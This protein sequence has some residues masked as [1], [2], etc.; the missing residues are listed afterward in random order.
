MKNEY[1]VKDLRSFIAR[2]DEVGQLR[3]I[4]GADWN[5]E[6]GAITE[7]VSDKA[8]P[9]LMFDNIAGYP[10]GF[11][12]LSN[13]F[14][15]H[16]RFG[17]AL[18]FEP[19]AHGIELLK[20]WRKKSK[21]MK[22][23]P[24]VEVPNAPVL[25]NRMEGKDVDVLAFPAPKWHE[26]DGG[27]YLGTGCCVITVDP[28][29]GHTNLGTYRCMVQNKT[30]VSIKANKGKHGRIAMEKYHAKGKPAPVAI[31]LGP[32]P[33]SF[34]SA[35]MSASPS[36]E[37]YELA[38]AIRDAPVEIVR[39]P[40]HGLPIPAYSEIVLEGEVP[41]LDEMELPQ[42]G[43]F[44][45]WAGYY[46]DT[47]TGEVPVMNVKAIY[48]RNNPII[49]GM[50]PMKPPNHYMSLPL[51]AAAL[52]DQLEAA[53]IPGITG[54][55]SFVYGGVIGPF[56]AI[57]IKQSYM[58]HS[59]QTL[60]CATGTRAGA[61]GGKFVV[62]VDDD[63]DVTD[64]QDVIWAMGTRCDPAESIDFLR[65]IWTSPADPAIS[66]MARQKRPGQSSSHHGYTM[67]RVLIDACRP[68]SW[69]DEFPEV[70]AF[71]REVKEQV[72]KKWNL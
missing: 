69:M 62:V 9:A 42:E 27:R 8:G 54:V 23:V 24:P 51:G 35:V 25:E 46:A 20:Q 61:Y 39:S 44:G 58:G 1:D 12:V 37:E 63:V 36:T 66:P 40:I 18:G 68:Y 43:P 14:R 56:V 13:A 7:A 67:T 65:G 28:E 26:Q 22:P 2:I 53:G 16:D 34:L 50:P 60:A 17:V 30:Q 38:G 49:L 5:V 64:L 19:G 29:N 71:P 55:W 31:S 32:D 59:K 47:T 70:N 10:K 72:A 3:R 41:P 4:D 11:R 6:I 15:T 52:W 21:T 57:S 45:E 48:Y 33:A